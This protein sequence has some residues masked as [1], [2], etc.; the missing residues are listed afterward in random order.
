M[1][2]KKNNSLRVEIPS[3]IE[4]M[5]F[6]SRPPSKNYK[7]VM[8]FVFV[9]GVDD[10]AQ[11]QS[12][13][14]EHAPDWQLKS[15]EEHVS[16]EVI[17]F[18]GV[19]GPVW[20]FC[21]KKW[22][23]PVSHGGRLEE[24]AYSWHRDQLGGL[25]GFCRAYHVIV[26]QIQLIST[27]EYQEKG[28]LVGL[29]MSAYSYKNLVDG[30]AYDGPELYFAKALSASVVKEASAIAKSINLAR[31]LVNS[32]PNELNPK[33]MTEF[34]SRLLKGTTGIQMEIWDEKRLQKEGM[35]LHLGVG[36]GSSTPPSLIHIRYRPTN[37]K[38]S[39]ALK[40]V[41]LVGKGVTFDT[42]GLDI[43]PSSSMRLMKKDMGGVA[44]LSGVALWL[45]LA[46]P[47]VPVDVYL[48][49]AENCVDGN[50]MRPSDILVA[51]NGMSVEIHNTDAEGR[52]VLADVLDVAVTQKKTDE[53]AM[54]IDVATLTGAIKSTLGT[55]IPGLFSNDDALAESLNKA[56]ASV[57]EPNW[58]IPLY[59]KYMRSMDSAFADMT[60]CSDG[61]GGAITAALFLEKFVRSKPWAH[62][63][64]YAW[65]DR[66][67]G[68]LTFAGGNGQTVQTLVEF[69][70]NRALKA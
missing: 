52:L 57:G 45:S 19:K 56:G 54:V 15:L 8:G 46:K 50:S 55:D 34:M 58:R 61:F 12:L 4:K 67:H 49:L 63:D 69:L 10:R 1:T 7:G 65:N 33:T 60:N 6:S 41:A 24:S 3:L 39:K 47:D 37:S 64:I 29:D 20:I 2:K 62:L 21:R 18:S 59:S 66:A 30:K 13:I 27:D 40:P 36:Q 22:Q 68:P 25:L 48:G 53:P 9:L 31:H 28:V 17:H 35:G 23:G 16:R 42:G 44:T 11:I 70:S 38:R 32:P 51:R 43:K 14:R 5:K 26:L